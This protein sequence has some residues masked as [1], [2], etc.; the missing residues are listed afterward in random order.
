MRD[1]YD[2]V[3]KGCNCHHPV[4]GGHRCGRANGGHG[5]CAYCKNKHI[6]PVETASTT[7]STKTTATKVTEKSK[8]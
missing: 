8:Q 7:T 2:D 4:H 3:E 5:K 1:G 6:Q